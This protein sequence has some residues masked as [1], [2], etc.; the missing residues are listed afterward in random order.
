MKYRNY[1][2]AAIAIILG[3]L[4]MAGFRYLPAPIKTT[5]VYPAPSVRPNVVIIMAD[6]MGWSDI[7]SY[8]GEIPTPNLD[9]LAR[10]GIRFS[11]FYNNARCCPTRASLLTGLYSHQAGIG[12]MTED[13]EHPERYHW[14]TPGYQGFLNRHCV[15]I[16]EALKTNGY[17]TYMTGKWHVGMHGKEKWP[18]QR[19]F[20][21]YYG[22]LAGATSYLKPQGG[23]GLTLDN[24]N[25]DPPTDPNYYTTDAFT[26]Y[27][28]RF[29]QEQKDKD[30]FF[31][32]LA[33]NAPHWP[34]HAKQADIAKFKGKYDA[35]WDVMRQQRLARQKKMGL[36]KSG[37]R[38]SARDHRVR[39][40]A[41]LSAGEKDST[42][43][44]MAVYAAQVSS[45]D[46][47]V[48]KLVAALK[49]RGQFDNTLILFLSDN[50]ACAEFYDELGSRPRSFINDPEFSGA[51]SY[52]IGWANNSNTP[53]FEY[54]VKPYEGG[55]RAP[56]IAHYPDGIK[57]QRGKITHVKGHIMDLMPTIL[58][59]TGTTYPKTFHNGQPIT[60][61]SGR[62]LLPTLITGSQPDPEYMYW[63]HEWYGAVRKGDWK[64]IYHLKEETWELYNVVSD[65][66][67]AHDEA[68][69]QP[70]LLADLQEHW[71]NWA[72]T[73]DVFPKKAE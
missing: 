40:W 50:G 3:G 33:F 35:G 51:V 32:Y 10:N 1:A 60:P 65:P 48:G 61:L 47:N 45:L 71:H 63:E 69:N 16:A 6:D 56:F 7:G 55:M 44:R 23:R 30:P 12:Q 14:G 53:L 70:A 52:G 54:K 27:A 68:K 37:T 5:S 31:L 2:F 49:K 13:P 38:L 43:Y 15:T 24:Q 18:L 58:D 4:A 28:I 59:L 36:F 73:H 8:G 26:D 62:S 20:D 17:H 42:A 22:I 72:N 21:R 64:A 34:L 57:S 46:Q 9:K 19:G 66:I 39:P 11:Q 29:I 25:L 67:E 41:D